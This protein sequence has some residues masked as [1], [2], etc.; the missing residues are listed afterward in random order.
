MANHLDEY[1]GRVW[2]SDGAWGTQM[3]LR[4]LPA[5][6]C[7]ELWNVEN[8]AAVEAVAASYVA[9]GSDVIISNTFGA[10][11]F[12]LAQHDAA[13]R[14]GEL[15]EAGVAISRRAAGDSSKVFASMGPS[16]KIVMMGDV[17]PQQLYEAFATASKAFANGGADAVVIET[18][19]ELAEVEVAVRAVRENTDLPV[20][21]SLTFD[22]GADKTATMM[23]VSPADVVASGEPAGVAGFGA[24]CGVGPESYV[25][26]V[27]LYRQATK[28]P[29]WV[30]ANAGL[31]VI[32]DGKNVFPLTP[33]AYAA[34]V[35]ALAA[36]GA[37]FIGGCCG[38]TPA[39]IAAVRKAVDAMFPTSTGGTVGI[40]ADTPVS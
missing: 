6:A 13:D 4:G 20:V 24:N 18:M 32:Q 34:F 7:P 5:G 31:P 28:A 3:Q 1:L 17:D 11:A 14:A 33:E 40:A 27:E 38:T 15:A 25:K 36:A 35:P 16:G 26:V 29:I 21:T 23:G 9:A 10:N 37:T 2:V 22:S 12:I 8:P 39:H 19:T 30:K